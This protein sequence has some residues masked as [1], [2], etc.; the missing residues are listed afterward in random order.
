MAHAEVIEIVWDASG[1]F[2][3]TLDVAPIKFAEVCERLMKGQSIAWSFKSDQRLNFNVKYH[4]GKNVMFLAKK[5]RTAELDREL[6]VGVDEDYCRMWG[7]PDGAGSKL[8]V[9]LRRR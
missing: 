1:R 7:N 8:T 5:D 6:Q 2:E 4:D 3:R 9:V